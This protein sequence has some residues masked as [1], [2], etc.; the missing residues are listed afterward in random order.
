MPRFPKVSNL[1]LINNVEET[2]VFFW[3]EK[4]LISSSFTNASYQQEMWKLL[5]KSLMQRSRKKN[6]LKKQK[7]WFQIHTWSDKSFHG[8]VVNRALKS[9]HGGSLENIYIYVRGVRAQPPPPGSVKSMVS[10]G[11]APTEA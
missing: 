8:T 7:P 6:I 2:V 1:Y 5:S 10:R 11:Q 9:L 3:L 4:F